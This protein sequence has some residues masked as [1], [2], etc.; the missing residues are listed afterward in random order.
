MAVKK[1]KNVLV[2]KNS[3]KSGYPDFFV[4]IIGI[5]DYELIFYDIIT[6]ELNG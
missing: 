2:I 3:K 5:N 1:E 4:V 6:L